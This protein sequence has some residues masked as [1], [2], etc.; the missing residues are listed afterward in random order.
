MRSSDLAL[1]QRWTNR[2]DAEAFA[3]IVARYAGMV[4]G[5]CRR[6]LGDATDAEDVA[7]EC[8]VKLSQADPAPQQSLGG[9]L[10]KVATNHALMCLRSKR[11]RC[12]R[13]SRFVADMPK[14]TE[15]TWD[16]VIR[17]TNLRIIVR[18]TILWERL[19]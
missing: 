15:L 18:S 8:F 3:E 13:E 1:L 14:Q 2:R 16:E 10:H 12:A 19:T 9:W 11:F 17:L 4:Y 7:Q 5:T 6:I